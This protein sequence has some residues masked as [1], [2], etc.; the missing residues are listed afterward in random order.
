[1]STRPRGIAYRLVKTLVSK[2]TPLLNGALECRLSGYKMA[3]G[4]MRKIIPE[5]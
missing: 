2:R 4:R 3:A 5:A 1:M